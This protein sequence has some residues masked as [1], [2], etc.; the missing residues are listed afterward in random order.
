MR[1]ALAPRREERKAFLT[2]GVVSIVSMLEATFLFFRVL[3]DVRTTRKQPTGYNSQ[4]G[5]VWRPHRLV[6]GIL[7]MILVVGAAW[8]KVN[9]RRVLV[10][11]RSPTCL[12]FTR[13]LLA[14]LNAG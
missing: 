1:R 6:A 7:L 9:I 5:C 14:R 13:G 4:Y 2:A 3:S 10:S 8:T 12:T 11:E